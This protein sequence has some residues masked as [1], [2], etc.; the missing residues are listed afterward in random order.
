M[1]ALNFKMWGTKSFRMSPKSDFELSGGALGPALRGTLA[2][3]NPFMRAYVCST[4]AGY[5]FDIFVS[6]GCNICA[7]AVLKSRHENAA[8]I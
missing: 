7:N 2:I 6:Q 3:L 8:R 4:L 5:E 1:R